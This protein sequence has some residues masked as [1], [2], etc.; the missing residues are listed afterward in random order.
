MKVTV[1]PA[2]ITTIEDRIAGNL[3]VSQLLLLS[4]PVFGGSAL[5]VILPPFFHAAFYKLVI[6]GM[7]FMMCGLLAIR[8]KD[9][10]VLFW[11]LTL[12]NYNLRP[13][14]YVFDKRSLNGRQQYENFFEDPIEDTVPTPLE[15]SRQPLSLSIA[16]VVELEDLIK[17]PD[18]HVRFEL[19]KGDLHVRL[20]EVKQES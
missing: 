5:F 17:N 13:R 9:K 1:V 12:F 15:V 7:L 3:G 14:Y 19:K 18:A 4:L 16:E 8:L 6:I 20:T 10:L 2:Q 11:L